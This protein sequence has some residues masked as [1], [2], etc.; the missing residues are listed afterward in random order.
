MRVS[1]AT[2]VCGL[3]LVCAVA[4]A[5]PVDDAGQV[6]TKGLLG[7]VLGG[8]ASAVGEALGI[9]VPSPKPPTSTSTTAATATATAV[10]TDGSTATATAIAASGG[11]WTETSPPKSPKPVP[12]PKPDH[13]DIKFECLD[14]IRGH[15]DRFY[16]PHV[17]MYG[18]NCGHGC[19]GT[20]YLDDDDLDQACY[21]HTVCVHEAGKDY[22]ARCEC[23]STLH[24]AA[25][26]VVEVEVSVSS[27]GRCP[28]CEFWCFADAHEPTAR[29]LAAIAVTASMSVQLSFEQCGVF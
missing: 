27:L 4:R 29:H 25:V 2:L 5:G 21:H 23:H 20:T 14:L 17:C 11:A 26:G 7:D 15:L 9:R 8:V 24:A 19:D 18:R 22:K 10:A 12:S 3:A 1:T 16:H 13:K 28:W 6:E